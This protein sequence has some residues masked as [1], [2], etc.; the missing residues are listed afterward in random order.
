MIEKKIFPLDQE[1]I[2]LMSIKDQFSNR[3]YLPLT[4]NV[5]KKKTE[6]K[7]QDEDSNASYDDELIFDNW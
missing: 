3:E 6:I 7:D 2:S 5:E 4:E 1:D